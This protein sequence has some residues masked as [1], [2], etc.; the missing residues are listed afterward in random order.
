MSNA[1]AENNG[2]LLIVGGA[3]RSENQEI[4]KA[5]IDAIPQGKHIAV[6]PLASGSPSKSA[7]AFKNDLISYGFDA[8]KIH[9]VPLAV[10]DDRSTD[11]ID[12]SQWVA[13]AN[14]AELVMALESQVGGYWFTGGDQMRILDALLPQPDKPTVFLQHLR[15]ALQQG[16]VIGGTSAG[17]AMMSNPM[18]AAGDSFNAV[19]K[20]STGQYYGTETQEIG[21][22]Y[23]HHGLGFF[24][25]GLVDQHFDR[26][27]RLGRLVRA[28][29]ATGVN[30]GYAVDEDT[31]M[32]IDLAAHTLKA[33][34]VG[35]VTVLNSQKAEFTPFPFSA[36]DVLLSSLI[37]GDVMD[38]ST[39]MVVDPIGAPTRGKE[40]FDHQALQG[41]GMAL[42]NNRVNRLLGYE[43]L[44]NRGASEVKRYNFL[45]SGEGFIYRFTQTRKSKGYWRVASGSVDGYTVE[46]VM[47]DIEPIEVT[48]T[49]RK[50]SD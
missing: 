50:A 7:A 39:G 38:L 34:G 21:Q 17:A 43:L 10:K 44:D 49:P 19:T 15:S 5:F 33:V 23:I 2:K 6:V 36:K 16:V 12:E 28:M 14:K 22:L 46:N 24:P 32:L 40:Y 27:A 3:L 18:I 35:S 29:A 47:L 25:Y 42:G 1:Q 13:N 30:Q 26:K 11:D 37:S 31:G 4:Y 20:K 8:D 48:I 45:D 41:A 9:I